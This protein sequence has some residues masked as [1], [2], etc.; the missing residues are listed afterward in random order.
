M[1]LTE[2]LAAV[3]RYAEYLEGLGGHAF[4]Q[5]DKTAVVLRTVALAVL[6]AAQDWP[7]LGHTAHG[8]LRQAPSGQ[9]VLYSTNSISERLELVEVGSRPA[10]APSHCRGGQAGIL[11]Q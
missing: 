1:T 4:P 2:Q 3:H 10:I 6:N 7:A 11:Q 5:R 8:V 9:Q